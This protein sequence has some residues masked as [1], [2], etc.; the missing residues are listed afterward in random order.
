MANSFPSQLRALILDMD[1][2][3]WRDAAPIGDLPAVFDRIRSLGLKVALA[4]NNATKTVGEYLEKFD[5]YGVTLEPWQIVTSSLATA[6]TL[7]KHF[8]GGGPVFVVGENGIQ[9][10]LEDFGFTAITDPQDETRPVAVVAGI[11]RFVSYQKLRRATL[12]IRAGAPFYGTN[13]DRTFPTPQGLVP[14]AGAIL[15]AIE[16]A[17]D[18]SPTVIGKPSPFMMKIALERLGTSPD[19]TLVVGD[20]LE[21]DIAAGQAAGCHTA[22]VLSGV[23]T[24]EQAQAWRPGMDFI[25]ADLSS[26]V[27]A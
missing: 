18:V 27:G 24:R 7:S 25:A 4:T 19:E 10:A 20:R 8:P 2:V 21:T 15:A 14:G 6:E 11:D 23:S 26:L 17:T 16:A 22:L 3:L 1:G 13:P 5:G 12:H 9:R